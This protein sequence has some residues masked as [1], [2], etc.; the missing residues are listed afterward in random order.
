MA[1]TASPTLAVCS[2]TLAM[3]HVPPFPGADSGKMPRVHV[4]LRMGLK[5]GPD[6]R[7]ASL[8]RDLVRSWDSWL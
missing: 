7:L 2:V 3:G 8:H 5:R 1:L 6:P 4:L